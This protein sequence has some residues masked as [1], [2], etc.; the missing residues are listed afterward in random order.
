MAAC[1][2]LGCLPYPATTASPRPRSWLSSAGGH[3]A[4]TGTGV[5]VVADT[6]LVRGLARPETRPVRSHTAAGRV[7]LNRCTFVTAR[8]LWSELEV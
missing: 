6:E 8:S 5:V 4:R 1:S 7:G 3:S 2:Q